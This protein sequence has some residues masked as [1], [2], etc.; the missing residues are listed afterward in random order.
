MKISGFTFIRNGIKLTYPFIESIQS[1]LPVCD[2]MIVVAGKSDDGTKEALL[3]LNDS[4]IKIIDTVWDDNLRTG[5]KILAQQT[6]IGLNAISGDWG[7]YLQGDEVVHEKEL[8][9]IV[10]TAEKFLNDPLTDGLLFNYYHFY[11]NYHYISKP[12]TRGT[13]PHEVRMVKKNPLIR[14]FRDAQGFRKFPSASSMERSV[15]PNK[16]KVRQV[17]AHIFHYG[18]VRGPKDEFE[19]SKDF[20]KLWHDDEW[21]R[22]FAANREVFD[23]QPDYPLISFRGSHPLVMKDRIRKLDWDYKYDERAVRIPLRH[24]FMNFLEQSTGLRPFD[25]KNYILL[26]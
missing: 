8:P 6:D 9:V 3:K 17:D 19:R 1:I 26:K 15:T 12:K 4:K 16:I 13:Y 10:S 23:Y 20:H 11:G 24:Q 18:K 7:F 5:G 22:Q 25:F 21:V 14:S 2:E